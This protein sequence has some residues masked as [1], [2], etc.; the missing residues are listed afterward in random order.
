MEGMRHNE[1]EE[2]DVEDSGNSRGSNPAHSGSGRLCRGDYHA[3]HHSH[4]NHRWARHSD[5]YGN[6]DPD[7]HHYTIAQSFTVTQSFAIA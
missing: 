5:S 7:G 1:H 3:D 4:Q 6:A 2:E